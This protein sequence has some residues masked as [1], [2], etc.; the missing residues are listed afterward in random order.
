MKYRIGLDIG[1]TSI[2]WATIIINNE[3]G[4]LKR[5]DKLGVRIFDRA[6]NPKDGSSLALARREARSMRR[7]LRRHRHRIQRAKLLFK[8]YNLIDVEKLEELYNSSKPLDDI[9]QIRVEA[10]D[11]KLSD[12]E[13][14]R[15]LIHLLQRRGFKSNRKAESKEKETGKLLNAVESNVAL[16]KEKNY[17]TIGEMLFLDEKFKEHKRNKKE[18]YSNT[19]PRFLLKEEIEKIFIAQRCFGNPFANEEIEKQYLSIFESQR[20]FE[21]GPASESPYA[22]NQIEKMLGFCTFEENEKRAPKATYSFE[23][24]MLLTKVN[25]LRLRKTG[26]GTRNLSSEER[27]AIIDLAYKKDKI[28]YIDLRKELSLSM[29]NSFVGLSYGRKAKDD[30]EKTK[31][32]ELKAYHAIRKALNNIEKN[33]IGRITIDQLDSIGYALTVYKNDAKITDF[34][35]K[36]GI[37][38]KEIKLLLPISF[39]K[40]GNLSIKAIKNI[41]PYLEE[42]MD[43][44]KACALAGYNFK[45]Y[46]G[47]PKSKK[48]P[49]TDYDRITNPVVKRALS[50]SIKVINAII[51]ANGAPDGI[52]IELVREMSKNFMERKQVEKSIDENRVRNEKIKQRLINEIGILNPTG[53]DIVKLKLFEEQDGFCLYSREKMDLHKVFFDTGYADIDHI[54]PYSISFDDSYNNKILVKGSENRQKGNQLPYEYLLGDK[55]KLNEFVSLVNTLKLSYLK[56]QNLLKMKLTEEEQI[57]FKERNLN[58][59]RYITRELANH[60]RNNLIFDGEENDESKR[61]RVICVNGAVTSY[62][63]KRWGL[64]K[65][66]EYGDIHHAVD[67]VVV[68]CIDNRI[69][70]N[71]SKY[72]K[73]KELGYGKR[74]YLVDIV[75]GEIIDRSE[76]DSRNLVK[77]LYKFPEPWFDFRKEVEARLMN[78]PTEIIRGLGLKTYGQNEIV[79]P[80]FISR[81][82][83]RKN[84]GL[85]H[86]ETIRSPKLLEEGYTI[87][88]TDLK[89]I[90]LKDGK[91]EG[92]YCPS[93]DRLLYEGLINRLIKFNGDAKKAFEEPFYKPTSSGT[94]GPLVK[95]V[96]ILSPISLGVMTHDGNGYAANG[97]MLRIDIFHRNG[98]YYIIPIYAADTLKNELPNKAIVANKKYKDWEEIDDTYNFMF[99]LYPNDLIYFEHKTGVNIVRADSTKELIKKGFVYYKTT[100]I[101][102]GACTIIAH[103]NSFK[104]ESLGIKTLLKLEK[105]Q[106]DYLGRKNRIKMEKRQGYK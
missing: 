78:N 54:I 98:K 44:D 69:I 53:N 6:E 3:S 79:E 17:R 55:E 61:Q 77:M 97:D 75:T 80:I 72:H 84:K 58:D 46:G 83:R 33:Y 21:E 26:Q 45:G 104:I 5:I 59:T 76:Y 92:Y 103:D 87:T 39:S 40:A 52:H 31:F 91:I 14:A 66:R 27:R 9:Y 47:G 74:G 70:H 42:G 65:I 100:N 35:K 82:A 67:A 10:L 20:S 2:G 41:L 105:W 23:R 57:E 4:E 89:D 8:K 43:Y 95:K 106:V 1:I 7:R 11:R 85:G 81:M 15:L 37:G 16:M 63:R 12:I 50:Q 13:M 49:H 18:D 56:K 48:L 30:V 68:S 64:S 86:L 38:E 88:K 51:D 71:V 93:S 94:P 32:I 36:L 102:S 96:K 99:T 90:K 25:N 60:I 62:M 101:S 28:T 19:V 22:G 34:L 29:D 73:N 24:F